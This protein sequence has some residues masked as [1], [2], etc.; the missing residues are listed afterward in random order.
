[1]EGSSLIFL[2]RDESVTIS[3]MYSSVICTR[4]CFPLCT[5]R[6]IILPFSR[7]S[8]IFCSSMSMT[9]LKLVTSNAFSSME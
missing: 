5:C 9:W 8:Y 2:M 3:F 7:W 4:S 6:F 1:M